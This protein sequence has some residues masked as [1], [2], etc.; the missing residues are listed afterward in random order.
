MHVRSGS[1]MSRRRFIGWSAGGAAAGAAALS[2]C[3]ASTGDSGGASGSD[4]ITIMGNDGEFTP[5]MRRQV[6]K[7]LDIQ[8]NF[9]AS[10]VTRL[11]AMLA[12]GEPPDLVRGMGA[13][14]TPY[15]AARQVAEDL[16]PYFAESKILK[17][18]DLDPVNDVWRYDGERQGAGPRYGMAKDYSQDTMFWFNT[19]LFDEAGVSDYPSTTEPISYDEWLD[20]GRR[21][22]VKQNGRT[23]VYGLSVPGTFPTLMAMTNNAGGSIFTDDMGAVDFGS[24]EARTALGWYLEYGQAGVGPSIIDPDPNGWDGPTYNAGRIAQS[25]AGYWFLGNIAAEPEVAETSELAPAPQFTSQRVSPN[26]SATGFWMP[27]QAQNKDAA[28]RVFE[29]FFGEQPAKDRAASGWGIPTLKSLRSLVPKAEPFQRRAWQV[30]EAEL[31]HFS[32]LSF[33]PYVRVEALDAVMNQVMPAALRGET[34]LDDLIGQLND[35][36]NEEIDR[37]KDL[38]E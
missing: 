14:E 31:E 9:V 26:L 36:M 8:V 16:D 24:P 28:W 21:L 2:G 13:L 25:S 17:V 20:L 5:E 10:D 18:D 12:S 33:T 35:R 38:V 6:A 30:Q 29:W 19:A 4:S 7:E 34:S 27:K 32:V 3:A 1:S 11:T 37:G 15:L 22:V 23:K